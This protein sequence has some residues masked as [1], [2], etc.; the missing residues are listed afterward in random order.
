VRNWIKAASLV[1]PLAVCCSAIPALSADQK[2]TTPPVMKFV[3][4][5]QCVIRC[6]DPHPACEESQKVIET[7]RQIFEACGREDMDTVSKYLADDCT[8]F[9]GQHKLIVGKQAVLDHIKKAIED[10]K[11]DAES[12]LLSYTIISPYA[13]VQGNSATVTYNAFKTYGGKHP[14][15]LESHSTDIFERHGDKWLQ[16]HYRNDWKEVPAI[17]LK[18]PTTGESDKDNVGVKQQ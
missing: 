2:T 16:S 4:S 14:R 17:S 10:H 8:G 1:A 3:E 6:F 18:V 12:P 5:N 7:L 9:T 11:N 15:T 13:E